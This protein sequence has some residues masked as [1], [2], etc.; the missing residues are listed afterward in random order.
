MNQA[1]KKFVIREL[2]K[3]AKQKIE[4]IDLERLNYQL[5]SRQDLVARYIVATGKIRPAKEIIAEIKMAVEKADA[6]KSEAKISSDLLIGE[7]TANNLQ[8]AATTSR[9]VVI[10]DKSKSKRARIE[11]VRSAA[12]DL[13]AQMLFESQLQADEVLKILKD[14][15]NKTF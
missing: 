9:N 15:E 1:Q 13:E 3:L 10:N 11:K 8:E 4:D 7:M 6:T 2:T 12:R 14:F 5:P